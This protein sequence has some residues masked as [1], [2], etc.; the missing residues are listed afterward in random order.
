[1]KIIGS[2]IAIEWLELKYKELL[3]CEEHLTNIKFS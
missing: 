3:F 1:M 2:S